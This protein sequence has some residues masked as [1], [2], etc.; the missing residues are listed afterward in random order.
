MKKALKLNDLMAHLLDCGFR[1]L[2]PKSNTW[3][4]AFVLRV[5]NTVL[6]ILTRK[7]GID[8]RCY[9]NYKSGISITDGQYISMQGGSIYRNNFN[10][11]TNL[12]TQKI[13]VIAK[14][15]SKGKMHDAIRMEDGK[16]SAAIANIDKI[17][18]LLDIDSLTRKSE[19]DESRDYADAIEFDAED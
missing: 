11:S 15:F 17:N 5:D 9:D 18:R 2:K 6:C 1:R 10:E 7:N 8:L 3:T 19:L 16:S 4:S 14:G 12:I 13:Y